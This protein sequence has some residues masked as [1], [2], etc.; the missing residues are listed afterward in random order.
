MHRSRKLVA[1]AAAATLALTAAA[2]GDDDDDVAASGD[3]T[4]TT[5][6]MDDGTMDDG[7]MAEAESNT[8][9]DV[10][11]GN[12]D[13]STLVTAVTT[14]E[15]Q[16]T[17]SSEGPFTVFAPTNAAFDALPEGT[18]ETLLEEESRDQ[19]TAILTYH[20]V[21]GAVM[22]GDLTDGMEVETVQGEVLTI[23]VDGSTVTITD[24]AGGTV[25][26]VRAVHRSQP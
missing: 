19:L 5:A 20:V 15:L 2:C 16:D 9:V 12:D 1:L 13:F 21:P 17:L 14:A 4:E 11:A 8:I 6:A 3:T 26:V 22:S 10:A 23:G 7:G 25:T 18:V 24:A